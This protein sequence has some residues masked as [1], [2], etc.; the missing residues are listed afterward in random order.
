LGLRHDVH[1]HPLLSI[2]HRGDLHLAH[3]L[4]QIVEIEGFG[5]ELGGALRTHGLVDARR[6]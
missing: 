1:A 6:S 3:S 5:E 4:P 2:A